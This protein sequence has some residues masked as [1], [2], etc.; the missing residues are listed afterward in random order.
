MARYTLLSQLITG[1]DETDQAMMKQLL[2]ELFQFQ[3]QNSR[4]FKASNHAV[5]PKNV[6]NTA[7][8][9]KLLS[10]EIERD[11]LN[12]M[13]SQSAIWISRPSEFWNPHLSSSV[14]TSSYSLESSLVHLYRQTLRLDS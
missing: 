1:N 12:L 5:K 4:L 11:T 13:Q 6:G 7:G 9:R 8:F 3:R 14:A 2:Q 10:F